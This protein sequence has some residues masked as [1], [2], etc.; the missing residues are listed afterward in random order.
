MPCCQLVCSKG[1]KYLDA[2]FHYKLSMEIVKDLMK[3]NPMD[4]ILS[5]DLAFLYVRIA[6]FS[7]DK[8]QSYNMALNILKTLYSSDKLA[9]ADIWKIKDIEANLA[10]AETHE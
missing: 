3:L 4:V 7:V 5:M 1:G 2:A 10:E 6:E 8:N 9:P